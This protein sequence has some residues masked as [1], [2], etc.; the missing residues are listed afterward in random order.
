MIIV[1][2]TV[3]QLVP[4]FVV[5]I[6]EVLGQWNISRCQD[7][8][9]CGEVQDRDCCGWSWRGWKQIAEVERSGP[10]DSANS[11]VVSLDS[12]TMDQGW[13][14]DGHLY[15]Y[16]HPYEFL[17]TQSS[18]LINEVLW[19]PLFATSRCFF[20]GRS[21]GW[22]NHEGR[23]LPVTCHFILCLD[24]EQNLTSHG[25]EHGSWQNTVLSRQWLRIV[26]HESTKLDPWEVTW[27]NDFP[28]LLKFWI[29]I[30]LKKTCT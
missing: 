9:A 22:E 4:A 11:L 2:S 5:P 17:G 18:A 13:P 6:W 28:D 10:W 3:V 25:C 16:T 7:C 19:S 29:P 20:F 12:R 21:E 26:Y 8:S 23:A 14:N 30:H 24:S 1:H 27:S 15:N